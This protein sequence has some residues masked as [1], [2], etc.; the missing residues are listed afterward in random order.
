MDEHDP[1]DKADL[2]TAALD[3]VERSLERVR[4]LWGI[5][6]LVNDDQQTYR[7]AVFVRHVKDHELEEM[8]D[9]VKRL[10]RET[11]PN[12]LR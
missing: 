3:A 12:G 11:T 2:L 5:T 7:P 1:A 10:R 4:R 9:D 8:R 6:S